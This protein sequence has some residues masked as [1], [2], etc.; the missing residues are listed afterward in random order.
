LRVTTA[1]PEKPCEREFDQYNENRIGV[2]VIGR[3]GVAA[4]D[5]LKSGK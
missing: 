4:S 2:D 1:Y 5:I 3:G